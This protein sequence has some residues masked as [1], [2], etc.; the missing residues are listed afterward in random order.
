M[1][2]LVVVKELCDMKG[3]HVGGTFNQVLLT[4]EIMPDLNYSGIYNTQS[5]QQTYA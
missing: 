2:F 5:S 3:N 4:D 1:I